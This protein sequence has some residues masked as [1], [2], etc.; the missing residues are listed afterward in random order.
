MTTY[1]WLIPFLIGIGSSWYLGG[2]A[3]RHL[4]PEG[5]SIRPRLAVLGPFA[6][7]RYFE[8]PGRALLLWSWVAATLGFAVAAAV[9]FRAA[10]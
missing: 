6:P 5:K 3:A 1:Y 4:S 10:T 9:I 8:G 7:A 2:K